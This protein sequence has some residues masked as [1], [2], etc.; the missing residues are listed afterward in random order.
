MAFRD[1]QKADQLRI[2]ALEEELD[3]KDAEI[4]RLRDELADRRDQKKPKKKRAKERAPIPAAKDLPEGDV[5]DVETTHPEG[6][7]KWGLGWFALLGGGVAY[8]A[9]TGGLRRELLIPVACFGLPGLM[10]LRRTGLT[11]DRKRGQITRWDWL[12]VRIRR[13]YGIEGKDLELV[14]RT[15][16]PKDRPSWSAGV[17]RIDGR[18]LFLMKIGK[19]RSLARRVAAFLGVGLSERRESTDEI[20]ARARQPL[21]FIMGF[22]IVAFIIA[23]IVTM[24]E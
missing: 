13:S 1:K 7:W 21:T 22:M 9:V 4:A 6:M 20:M 12:F 2:G 5:W 24:M 19:A 8:L 3:E 23:G 14:S 17:L 11:V 15:M 10:L 18:D 16:T